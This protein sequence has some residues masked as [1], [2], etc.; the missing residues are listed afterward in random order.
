[1]KMHIFNRWSDLEPVY[2][3]RD[4]FCTLS[5]IFSVNEKTVLFVEQNLE[6]YTCER[7]YI[8]KRKSEKP[9]KLLIFVTFIDQLH[10]S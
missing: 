8:T 7:F 3:R 10:S 9:F 2:V 4:I 5:W 1:M 6:K